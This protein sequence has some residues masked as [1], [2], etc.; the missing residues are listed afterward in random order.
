MSIKP[1]IPL[2]SESDFFFTFFTASP[3]DVFSVALFSPS[4]IVFS[5]SENVFPETVPADLRLP[6]FLP[7]FFPCSKEASAL[8]APFPSVLFFDKFSLP[9]FS[10]L[11]PCPEFSPETCSIKSSQTF[12]PASISALVTRFITFSSFATGT[13]T[14]SFTAAKSHKPYK[15]L[16]DICFPKANRIPIISKRNTVDVKICVAENMTTPPHNPTFYLT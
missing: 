12:H 2:P 16:F 5:C 1:D 3:A 13:G 7:V 9:E 15:S 14:R 4:E 11:F 6:L 10:P 8:E